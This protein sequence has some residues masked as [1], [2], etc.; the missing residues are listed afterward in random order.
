M[1]C[2][3]AF[4]GVRVYEKVE[5]S[6]RKENVIQCIQCIK[7][8][9]PCSRAFHTIGK[10]TKT[11]K[12]MWN[13]NTSTCIHYILVVPWSVSCFTCIVTSQVFV[14]IWM[15]WSISLSSAFYRGRKHL[16]I[17]LRFNGLSRMIY[18]PS[19]IKLPIASTVVLGRQ[20][21]T[22]IYYC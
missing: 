16:W 9:K 12:I 2:F 5:H 7:E 20:A 6:Q 10:Q 15:R 8:S 22:L 1:L 3:I 18:C 19:W 21:W 13:L 4:R 14:E 11:C 17:V